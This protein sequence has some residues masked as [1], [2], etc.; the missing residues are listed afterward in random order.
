MSDINNIQI[1]NSDIDITALTG[2]NFGSGFIP[3]DELVN[4]FNKSQYI[5]FPGFCDVHV[6]FRE[7]GFSYKETI[8]TG[9]MSAARGGY[10]AVCTM[11]NLK[12]VP[13]SVSHIQEELDIIDRDAVINV[14]PYASITVN[15]EGRELADMEGLAPLAI[16][17]S[18]DGK[19]IQD[20]AMMH[21]AMLKARALDKIIVAHCEVNDLLR[22]GYIHDGEYARLH[23][24]RGICSESEWREIERDVRL[25]EETGCAYHVCHI[26]TKESVQI[27]R[28]AKARGVNV[29]CET[30]PHYLIMTDED[31]KEDGRFKMN[32][33]IRSEED[34]IALVEGIKDG[35]IDMIITDH[36]PHSA[37]EKSRGLEK[38]AMG[39]VGLETAFASLYTGLV[40][41]GVITL[42]KLIEL[43]VY[44]PRRRFNIPLSPDDFCIWD[45]ESEY[46]VDPT[47]FLSMGHATP[48]EGMKLCGRCVLTVCGGKAAY[49]DR[50]Q[51]GI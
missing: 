9:T 18:D 13:D 46:M 32:P 7:P 17:Y 31:L 39:V 15:E 45:L 26:S 47:E 49:I 12:P 19:G 37:E 4:L 1:Y 50:A 30:G 8:R 43:M 25:A 22:G 23:G 41:T 3:N 5:V 21:E 16:A 51:L 11:P 36:A 27:I 6:H 44:A 24:H 28:E 42:D 20:E 35:T 34:R 40:K 33:P 48:F 29:T 10:T 38:S 14:Y 2:L